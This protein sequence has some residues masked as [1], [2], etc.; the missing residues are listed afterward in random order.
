MQIFHSQQL[1]FK[2]PQAISFK[3]KGFY[4]SSKFFFQH[5]FYLW[6]I[7]FMNKRVQIKREVKGQRE[8]TSTKI[9]TIIQ[10]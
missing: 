3:S 7:K 6:I 4:N 5:V 2:N 10:F 9:T 8:K 1:E